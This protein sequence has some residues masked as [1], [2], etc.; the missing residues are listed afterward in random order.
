MTAQLTHKPLFAG[1]LRRSPGG[2]AANTPIKVF[3]AAERVA[4]RSA[5]VDGRDVRDRT[6]DHTVEKLLNELTW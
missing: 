5:V 3:S 6:I 4:V 2:F 1:V